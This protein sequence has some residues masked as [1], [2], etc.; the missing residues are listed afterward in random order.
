MTFIAMKRNVLL[1]ASILLTGAG[2]LRTEVKITTFEECAK[3]GNPVMESYPRQCRAGGET[4]VEI[5]A[6]PQPAP[7]PA[8]QPEAATLGNPVVLRVGEAASFEGGLKITLKAINDSRCPKDVQCVWAGEL[9][10]LVSIEG[11]D[12]PA[13]ALRLG[14]TTSPKGAAYGFTLALVSIDEASATIAVTKE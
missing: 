11:P 3:A 6:A 5:V 2:C 4:F 14:Q 10:A 12:A 8:P 9:A 13:I 7:E 1:F